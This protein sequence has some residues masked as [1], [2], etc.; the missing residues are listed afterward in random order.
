MFY[1]ALKDRLYVLSKIFDERAEAVIQKPIPRFED[2]IPRV[3]VADRNQ[4][5]DLN[6]TKPY[7]LP[8]IYSM[9]DSGVRQ[10]TIM[11]G[12]QVSKTELVFALAC[13]HIYYK[14]GNVLML[15][16][17][18]ATAMKYAERLR[19]NLRATP[20]LDAIFESGKSRIGNNGIVLWF[21]TGKR[22]IVAWS[23]SRMAAAGD[24]VP[25]V[26]VDE[27]DKAKDAGLTGSH[28]ENLSRRMATY[29]DALMVCACTPDGFGNTI[30]SLYSRSLQHS[31]AIK[32][33][34]CGTMQIPKFENY[35]WPRRKC[36]K[37][38]NVEWWTPSA[39]SRTD[40]PCP[41][42]KTSKDFI[43]VFHDLPH[44]DYLAHIRKYTVYSC[45][46]CNHRIS[47]DERWGAVKNGKF[48]T[49]EWNDEFTKFTWDDEENQ[50]RVRAHMGYHVP[51]FI[52]WFRP[53][54]AIAADWV[55]AMTLA[56]KQACRQNDAALPWIPTRSAAVESR[57]RKM[58]DA[59]YPHPETGIVHLPADT[60]G[61][62]AA[63][64]IQAHEIYAAVIAFR[65]D[66]R[67]HVAWTARIRGIADELDYTEGSYQ[68]ALNRAEHLIWTAHSW[69]AGERQLTPLAVPDAKDG[70]T[71]QFVLEWCRRNIN[72]AVP[73]MGLDASQLNSAI[74]GREKLHERTGL[75]VIQGYS[76]SE[77]ERILREF[78]AEP[79]SSGSW[80]FAS[81]MPAEFYRH[82]TAWQWEPRRKGG[83]ETLSLVQ[84]RTEDHWM[85]CLI[86]ASV[87]ARIRFYR[88]G[89]N[90][91]EMDSTRTMLEEHN[92]NA[93]NAI[94]GSRPMRR[95]L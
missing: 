36:E 48:I 91:A 83:A 2:W 65:P 4:N 61:V 39:S 3:V 56:D 85:D 60:V 32:C 17:D 27:I 69:S 73:W 26:I 74:E 1:F 29:P 75:T 9:Q 88:Y 46:K 89:Q 33:P 76:H 16:P 64:D 68:V 58:E 18:L 70:M 30:S 23:G 47:E 14:P 37:C 41:S 13:W 38:Q 21:K 42:C 94:R 45:D 71:Q 50:D 49:G 54:G 81:G 84:R 62:V 34:E 63:L 82:L 77:R 51:A 95:V 90:I 8:I 44:Q 93:F 10:I 57:L 6:L 78:N 55:N 86:I 67:K 79:G 19:R 20:E 87:A 11:G 52:S 43:T 5:Y 28:V 25:L 24:P 31:Y 40:I 80:T 12:A 72:R 66:M 15:Y 35:R 53:F 22:I 92:R 7:V 59:K